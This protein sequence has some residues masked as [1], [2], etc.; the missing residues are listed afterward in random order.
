MIVELESIRNEF[1][2]ELV[3]SKIV[4]VGGS[5]RNAIARLTCPDAIAINSAD[6]SKI[7]KNLKGKVILED[8][9]MLTRPFSPVF[10]GRRVLSSLEPEVLI[11]TSKRY[12]ITPAGFTMREVG[13]TDEPSYEILVG[14]GADLEVVNKLL[15]LIFKGISKKQKLFYE[16]RKSWNISR[17][18]F[19]ISLLQMAYANIITYTMI[20][21]VDEGW[22]V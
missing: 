21:L 13:G 12:L 5:R 3:G 1:P 2:I 14:L 6:L 18:K 17:W 20:P 19:E 22:L 4:L 9:A 11:V 15:N 7:P 8:F 16:Y 10:D